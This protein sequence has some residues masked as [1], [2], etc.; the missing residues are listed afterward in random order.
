MIERAVSRTIVTHLK[1]RYPAVSIPLRYENLY[2]LCIAVVLSAQTTDNQVN[3]VTPALFK[4]YPDFISLANAGTADVES[5]IRPTG[6]YHSKAKHIIGL[7]KSVIQNFN[8][9]LPNTREELMRLPGVGRKSANVIL[10][11]G[12]GI[13]AIPVDTHVARVAY[14]IGYAEAKKPLVIEEAIMKSIPQSQWILS[15]TL[16]IFH[17]RTLCTSR[18]PRCGIC[19]II[20]LCGFPDKNLSTL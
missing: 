20:A 8:T 6:F 19:P 5:I 18:K 2:Q 15:H 9:V 17:G 7:S 1:K 11:M 10:S 16:F 4:A 14:R 13:P 3:M 12:F